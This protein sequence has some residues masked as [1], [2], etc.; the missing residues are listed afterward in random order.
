MGFFNP[1]YYLKYL[2]RRLPK[3]ILVFICV[4]LIVCVLHLKGYCVDDVNAI[5]VPNGD[6]IELYKTEINMR[7]YNALYQSIRY[8]SLN[9]NTGYS[10]AR[11]FYRYVTGNNGNRVVYFIADDNYMRLYAKTNNNGTFPVDSNDRTLYLISSY[12]EYRYDEENIV[13]PGLNNTSSSVAY[14]LEAD[15]YSNCMVVAFNTSGNGSYSTVWNARVCIP[16]AFVNYYPTDIYDITY[17]FGWGTYDFQSTSQTLKEISQKIDE[18]NAQL[19]DINEFLNDNTT[20]TVT[21]NDLPS[22]TMNDITA[23][24]FNG[25][26]TKIYNEVTYDNNSRI[27]ITIPYVNYEFYLYSNY[28]TNTLTSIP[29][30]Q[31]FTWG[32]YS[33]CTFI[34]LLW[35]FAIYRY[36][37]LDIYKYINQIKNGDIS[38]TDTNIKADML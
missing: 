30:F 23:S 13:I 9:N 10:N 17:Q 34:Q 4:F 24:G 5:N 27:K 32:D 31:N 38:T 21:P 20:P 16:Y 2:L 22:D 19:D 11:L 36:I 29:L 6:V 7:Y 33:I 26:F 15:W 12:N 25:I 1:F 28:L 37:V 35:S 14:E 18:T 3:K 8:A